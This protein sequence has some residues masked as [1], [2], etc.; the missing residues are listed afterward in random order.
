M[1][2]LVVSGLNHAMH[3][4]EMNDAFGKNKLSDAD[5]EKIYAAYP[6]GDPNNPNYVSRD[7]LYKKIGGAIYDDYIQ[8]GYNADGSVN[9]DYANTCALR[10]SYALN[11][12]GYAI[13]KTTGTYEGAKGLNYFYTVEYMKPYLMNTYNFTQLTSGSIRNAL[14]IQTN[15]GWIDASGHID[16]MFR[17][18]AGSEFHNECSTNFYLSK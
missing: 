16:I 8:N 9:K 6:K 10:M 3:K 2:G 12:A 5:L 13:N 18:R 15:C 1:L 11:K 17:G 4:M 7:D 14:I